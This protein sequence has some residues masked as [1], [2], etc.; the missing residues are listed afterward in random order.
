[1]ERLQVSG[2]PRQYDDLQAFIDEQEL[3][4]R[5]VA[6]SS[7]PVLRLDIS[8]NDVARA[9]NTIADWMESTGGLW[10]C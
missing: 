10:R 8:D 4:Q 1:M 5:L 6:E 2:N 9:V 3:L 7:L